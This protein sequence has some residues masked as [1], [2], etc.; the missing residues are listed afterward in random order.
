MY[1][2]LDRSPSGFAGEHIDADDA[3]LPGQRLLAGAAERIEPLADGDVAEAGRS[4]G[5]E[6]LSL[7]ESAGDSTGPEVDVA[8]DGFR[9][10]TRDDDVAV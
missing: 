2:T 4:E 6:E 8:S 1:L 9:Q 5:L 3:V 10:L 7:R